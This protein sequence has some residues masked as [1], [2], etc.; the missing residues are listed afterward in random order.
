MVEIYGKRGA[1]TGV[2]TF[3]STSENRLVDEG[4]KDKIHRGFTTTSG[5]SDN[6]GLFNNYCDF[7]SVLPFLYFIVRGVAKFSNM[8]GNFVKNADSYEKFDNYIICFS[9][10]Q[11]F[12]FRRSDLRWN[13]FPITDFWLILINFWI[14]PCTFSWLTLKPFENAD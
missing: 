3:L 1:Y 2:P 11:Y 14:F 12:F 13:N 5:V 4:L 7:K 8:G 9:I 6:L 10:S